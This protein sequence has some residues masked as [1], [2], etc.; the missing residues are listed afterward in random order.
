MKIIDIQCNNI[1]CNNIKE[2]F[3]YKDTIIDN[4]L[5]DKCKNKVHII[6]TKPNAINLKGDGFYNT[7]FIK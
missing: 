7:G 2:I 1:E 5:C 6:Y 4:I 3:I